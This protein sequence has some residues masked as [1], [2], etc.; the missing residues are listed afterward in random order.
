VTLG[1]PTEGTSSRAATVLL[2]ELSA[3]ESRE[4]R[5]AQFGAG[6]RRHQ[7]DLVEEILTRGIAS[8]EFAVSHP[9]PECAV[10]LLGIEDGFAASVIAGWMSPQDSVRLTLLLAEQLTGADFNAPAVAH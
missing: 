3:L 1:V 8:G 4:E 10:L 6:F 5:I 9:V 2:I 7:L